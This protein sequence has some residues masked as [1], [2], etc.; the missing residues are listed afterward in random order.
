MHDTGNEGSISQIPIFTNLNGQL[1]K[2]WESDPH[3]LTDK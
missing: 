3:R 2:I 1:Q